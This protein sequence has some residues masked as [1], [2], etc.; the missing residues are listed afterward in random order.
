LGSSSQAP[1][2]LGSVGWADFAYPLN[3]APNVDP[4]KPFTWINW[5]G[6]ANQDGSNLIVGTSPGASDVFNSGTIQDTQTIPPYLTGGTLQV[7][8]LQPNTKYYARLTGPGAYITPRDISFTTGVGRAH[9]TYPAD[10]AQQ[11]NVTTPVTLT[12]NAVPG[13]LQYVLWLGSTPGGNDIMAGWPGLATSATITRYPNI[14]YYARMW[15]QES[16]GQWVY[17]DSRFSTFATDVAFASFPQNGDQFATGLTFAQVGY[18][19]SVTPVL[20]AG[21]KVIPDATGYTVWVGTSPGAH[22]V[23]DTYQFN[24]FGNVAYTST[25]ALNINTTYYLRIWTQKGSL[26]Y[27][28]DSVFSTY[29]QN[30]INQYGGNPN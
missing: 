30:P 5:I 27:Y 2:Y 7:P 17:V 19:G 11:V 18:L 4:F 23:V 10:E 6:G 26:W 16:D 8:G 13:A 1:G 9:L 24:V 3:G 21:W 22:D 20:E 15:T 14:A 12:C 25:G 29:S 28:T